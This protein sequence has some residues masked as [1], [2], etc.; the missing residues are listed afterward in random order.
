MVICA[1]RPA[2]A[3]AKRLARALGPRIDGQVIEDSIARLADTW[4]SDEAR[5]GV[6]AFLDKRRPRWVV[7]RRWLLHLRH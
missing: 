1:T 6:T 4:D 7:C 5:E 3:A 2:G